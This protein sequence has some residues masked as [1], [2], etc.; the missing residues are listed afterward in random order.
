M[1]FQ[2]T[3]DVWNE[4]KAFVDTVSLNENRELVG[5]DLED[6]SWPS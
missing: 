3:K 5:Y 1:L 6:S 2:V 4:L